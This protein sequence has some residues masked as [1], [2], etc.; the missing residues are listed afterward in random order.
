MTLTQT[1]FGI[2]CKCVIAARV[3]YQGIDFGT[4]F[5]DAGFGAV[6]PVWDK[7]VG[8]DAKQFMDEARV[9]TGFGVCGVKVIGPLAQGVD[10]AFETEAFDGHDSQDGSDASGCCRNSANLGY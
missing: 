1:L 6:G 4:A 3:G 8:K 2:G 7:I 5:S 10:G 9:H